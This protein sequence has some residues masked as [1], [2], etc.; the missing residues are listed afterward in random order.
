MKELWDI[1]LAEAIK[2]KANVAQ[3]WTGENEAQA[4]LPHQR[5]RRSA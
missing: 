5:R 3:W 2:H 4:G 1:A